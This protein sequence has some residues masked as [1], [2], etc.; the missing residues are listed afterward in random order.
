MPER[1]F[2]RRLSERINIYF[3]RVFIYTASLLL[4]VLALVSLQ[5]SKSDSGMI[6]FVC[7]FNLERTHIIPTLGTGLD[8]SR[9]ALGSNPVPLTRVLEKKRI[10]LGFS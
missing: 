9:Q 1:I 10:G 2:V 8:S 4:P 5:P 3:P 7:D 6:L